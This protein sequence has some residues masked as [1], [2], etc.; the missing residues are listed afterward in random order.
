MPAAKGRQREAAHNDRRVLDAARE[1]FATLGWDAPVAAVAERAGVGMGSLYRRYGS[2]TELLQRLCVLAMEQNI[3]AATR[4]LA[5]DDP[6][7]ALA[8]YIRECVG[9]NAGAFA[10]LAGTLDVTDDMIA[11]A[12]RGQRLLT[13]L[14]RRAQRA[15]AVR[16]DLTATDVTALIEQFSR[17]C[18]NPAAPP[19][20]LLRARI[21]AVAIHG[22]RPDDAAPLPGPAPSPHTYA[23][24]WGAPA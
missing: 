16:G 20:D 12:R 5:V 22:L 3:D 9:F 2:K 7:E 14:L 23:A 19:D 1:V 8:Q 17:P 15:G 6:A 11:T 10:P 18:A 21:L 4:G 24:R 13:R